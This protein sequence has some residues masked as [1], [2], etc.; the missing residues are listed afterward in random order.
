MEAGIHGSEICRQAS[1]AE[2]QEKTN[3]GKLLQ[4]ES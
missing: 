2:T 1:G 3:S 4:A